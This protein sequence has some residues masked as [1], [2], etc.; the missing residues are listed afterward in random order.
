MKKIRIAAAAAAA[1]L[2]GTVV[3]VAVLI[4]S[5]N[6]RTEGEISMRQLKQNVRICRDEKGMA[7]IYAQNTHD[8]F[9]AMGFA[10][11]QDRLFQ[12]EMSRRFAQGKISEVIGEN[13]INIDKRMRTLGFNKNAEKHA[14]ILSRSTR[15]II[16]WYT[17]GINEFIR[18]HEHDHHAEF[19][20]AGTKPEP[21]GIEDSLSLLYYM[22][23]NSAGDLETE[24]I[25]LMLA[26]KLGPDRAREI[27]P[28]NIHPE[29][30]QATDY[31]GL[32]AS[33]E[34]SGIHWKEILEDS[35]LRSF[36]E[37][38]ARFHA[39]SNNWAV[40]GERSSRGKP[41]VANDPH[42]DSRI[43]PGPWYPCA[44]IMPE[45]RITGVSVPGIPAVVVGRNSHVAF[46]VTN[47]Y[48]DAQDLY[49]ETIDPD[50]PRHYMEGE[51]SA[52]FETRTETIKIKD[53]DAQGGMREEKITIR[54]T[55]RGPVVSDVLKGLDTDHVITLRWSPFESMTPALGIEDLMFAQSAGDVKRALCSVTTIM[56]NFVFADTG[57][58]I[59]WQ[60][61][62]RLP[63]RSRGESIMPGKVNGEPDDWKGWIPYGAMPQEYNPGKQWLGTCNHKT[64]PGDYPYYIS[65]RFAPSYRYERLMELMEGRDKLTVDDHWDFQRDKKNPMAEK[66]LPVMAE[67]LA[68]K[69]ETKDMA[70][71]LRGWDLT[72][73][74]DSAG[75]AVF[76]AVY[77]EFVYHT[78]EDELGGRLMETF[79]DAGYFWKERLQHMV[80]SGDSPWFDD[81][82]T[83]ERETMSDIFVQAAVSAKSALENKLGE[84]PEKWQ[85]GDL[86]K[87]EFVSPIMRSGFLKS[88]LGG[89]AHPMGGSSETL[90]RAIYAYS[91]PFDVTVS[92]SLRMVADLGDPDKVAAVLPCGVA[93]R[94][95]HEHSKDQTGAFMSGEKLY[96]WFSDEKIEEHTRSQLVLKA[97]GTGR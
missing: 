61:T 59:G 97:G 77:R 92:A 23:W 94:Q 84:D 15:D 88:A 46:G 32:Q 51:S 64:V 5:N 18:S 49:I 27:F 8:A 2:I 90:Y 10:A 53:D 22:G 62:G 44:L 38:D 55:R 76:Q 50:N 56:L 66:I 45:E 79:A 36:M 21:W 58:N 6:Y 82:N 4:R 73:S 78:F 30:K 86:H 70:E 95:F 17:D 19:R 93:G 1:V 35:K 52:A 87:L 3:I 72:D 85:W 16:R 65:S 37:T 25:A 26:E 96:W 75:A 57:G 34:Q 29:E 89:G 24:I 47:S 41:V 60:T 14:E 39:G 71:I 31:T 81:I 33:I 80:L 74:R 54:S 28:L 67:S 48:G 40:S 68:G 12:M 13:G 7:Y 69:K 20:L 9:F 11:A 43:M 63:V 83:S 42:L 91:D